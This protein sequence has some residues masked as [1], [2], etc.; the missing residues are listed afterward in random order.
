MVTVSRIRDETRLNEWTTEFRWLIE[1]I[2]EQS[3]NR[4]IVEGLY[5]HWLGSAAV[6]ARLIQ[7]PFGASQQS[8]GSLATQPEGAKAIRKFRAIS[9]Q[10][11]D[12]GHAEFMKRA[13]P[14]LSPPGWI[15]SQYRR[16]SKAFIRNQVVSFGLA[17]GGAETRPEHCA[18]PTRLED[19]LSNAVGG[20]RWPFAQEVFTGGLDSTLRE[21]AES[22]LAEALLET[23]LEVPQSWETEGLGQ[24]LGD[25]FSEVL[26]PPSQETAFPSGILQG[27]PALLQGLPKMSS[28]LVWPEGV[29]TPSSSSAATLSSRP[30]HARS[31]GNTVLFVAARLDISDAVL[32]SDLQVAKPSTPDVGDMPGPEEDPRGPERPGPRL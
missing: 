17:D 5:V 15:S 20:R 19:A 9:L 28:F 21:S 14:R 16:I 2:R 26:P 12:T 13:G 4:Q 25:V 3:K 30:S 24:N 8:A 18:F 31:I 7:Q 29:D 10:L 11:T 32:S 6:L 27:T 1:E 23:Y 22:D